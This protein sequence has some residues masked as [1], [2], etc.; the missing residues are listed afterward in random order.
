LYRLTAD[1]LDASRVEQGLLQLH[2]Q[3]LDLADLVRDTAD[4][5]RT[6]HAAITVHVPDELI[7]EVDPD[8]IQQAL[9]NLLTNAR[10]H[11]P[12]SPVV[13]TLR[14]E[15]RD[16]GAWAIVRVQDGGPGIAPAIVDSLMTRFVR[17]HQSKGLGLG[18]YLASSIAQA[19]GGALTVESTLG[20][21]TTFQLAVPTT[22]S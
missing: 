14:Q 21:G 19:H 16:T 6:P 9:E 4:G 1:L 2:R 12:G 18:L 17:G 20:Q 13:V 22:T 3:P 5:L 7:A 15:A 8:R 11:A 10:T